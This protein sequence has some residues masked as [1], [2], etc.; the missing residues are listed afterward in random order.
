MELSKQRRQDII[1]AL[2]RGTVPRSSLDKFAVGLG[3]FEGAIDQELQDC[4]VDRAVFKA[5]RGEYGCGK[6]FFLY[7]METIYPFKFSPVGFPALKNV[8]SV[9]K[10]P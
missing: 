5:V 10:Y 8:T 9:G 7:H 3:R 4:K 1:N 6:T 2:R